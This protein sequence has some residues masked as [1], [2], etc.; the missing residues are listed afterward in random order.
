[1]VK[2][3]IFITIVLLICCNMANANDWEALR[4][5]LEQTGVDIGPQSSMSERY[6][7]QVVVVETSNQG[8]DYEGDR[9]QTQSSLTDYDE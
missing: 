1:M 3:F 5:D 4:H 6:D 7:P 2:I 8:Y 9:R